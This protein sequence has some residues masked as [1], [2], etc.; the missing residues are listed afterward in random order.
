M[1]K[2]EVKYEASSSSGEESEHT[3]KE[4]LSEYILARDRVRRKI[5]P[6]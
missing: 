6:P 1:E 5:K 2:E 3:Q 4:D